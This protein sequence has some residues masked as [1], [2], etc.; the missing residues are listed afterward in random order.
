M[1]LKLTSEQSAWLD[2]ICRFLSPQGRMQIQ[3]TDQMRDA[4]VEILEAEVERM[5]LE[6]GRKRDLANFLRTLE[7]PTPGEF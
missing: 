3:M 1:N 2:E 6:L 4:Y 5:Q 7:F